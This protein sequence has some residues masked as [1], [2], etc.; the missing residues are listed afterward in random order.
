MDKSK[1]TSSLNREGHGWHVSSLD[2]GSIRASLALQWMCIV[3]AGGV[4]SLPQVAEGLD[5]PTPPRR[6][7]AVALLHSTTRF[8]RPAFHLAGKV[9]PLPPACTAVPPVRMLWPPSTIGVMWGPGWQFCW[10]GAGLL[11]VTSQLT[12]AITKELPH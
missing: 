8:C 7:Q 1:G 12:V 3:E 4:R 11:V 9:A 5:A 6:L 10:W 2:S